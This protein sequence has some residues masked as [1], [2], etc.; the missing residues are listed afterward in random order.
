MQL[1]CTWVKKVAV[2]VVAIV[3]VAGCRAPAAERTIPLAIATGGPGGAFYPMGQAL[4]A[5]YSER[6]P[7]VATTLLTGGSTQN[8]QAVQAGQAT[9]GFTQADVAYVAYRRGTEGDS[10]PFSDLRG[11]A[12]PWMNTVHVAVPRTSAIQSVGELGGR[13]IAVGTRGSGTETLA[14]IVLE[15]YGLRYENIRP[16]FLSFIQTIEGMD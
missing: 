7:G 3:L 14:R 16:E 10:R 4:A 2:P 1:P 13:R 5:L 15:S 12:M 9:I 6:V 8:V 11:V